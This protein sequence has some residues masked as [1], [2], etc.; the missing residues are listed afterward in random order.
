MD[1][2]VILIFSSIS[3]IFLL[4]VSGKREINQQADPSADE[5][6]HIFRGTNIGQWLSQSQA[7]GERRAAYFTEKDIKYIDSIGFDHIRLPIDE[8]QMWDEAGNR[9]IGKCY[10]C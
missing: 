5:S 4:F 9:N 7:R 8:A 3:L 2:Q 1:R 6:F 10:C